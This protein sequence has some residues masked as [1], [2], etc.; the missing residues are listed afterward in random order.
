MEQID[1]AGSDS[2]LTSGEYIAYPDL[3]M[4]PAVFGLPH[5]ESHVFSKPDTENP[6]QVA[7]GI[8]PVY[9]LPV[10]DPSD[11]AQTLVLDRM[12]LA[13]IFTGNI[14]SWNDPALLALQSTVVRFKLQAAGAIKIT[15]V[16]RSDSAGSTEVLAKALDR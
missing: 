8:V 16:V 14:T 4:F 1:F 12:T 15:V 3:Q 9:N 6:K 13:Y 11:P 2:L 5:V 7:G 10:L